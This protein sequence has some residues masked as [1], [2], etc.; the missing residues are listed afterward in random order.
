MQKLILI[1]HIGR[2]AQVNNVGGTNVTNFTVASSETYKDKQGNKQ[3]KTTWFDC[4]LWNNDK[5]AQYLQKGTQVFV[6][7]QVEARGFAKGDGTPGSSLSVRVDKIQLLGGKSNNGESKDTP[8]AQAPVVDLNK[9][10]EAI[11]DFELPF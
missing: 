5:L 3:T 6:E 7:G 8:S 1:G 2:D 10:T 11:T 4:A 9:K